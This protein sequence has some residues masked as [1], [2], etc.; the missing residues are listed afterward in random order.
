M[1]A[2]HVSEQ[3]CSVEINQPLDELERSLAAER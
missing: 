2:R 3:A 1:H